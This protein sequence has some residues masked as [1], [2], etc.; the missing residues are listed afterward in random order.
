MFRP[1]RAILRQNKTSEHKKNIKKIKIKLHVKVL[2]F[3]KQC[4][5]DVSDIR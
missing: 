5:M 3:Y 4:F 1:L 2:K